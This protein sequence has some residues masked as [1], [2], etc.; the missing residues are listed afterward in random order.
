MH[1]AQL[2]KG[3]RRFFTFLT[4]RNHPYYMS[5]RSKK[6]ILV[7]LLYGFILDPLM[8]EPLA[9]A[10]IAPEHWHMTNEVQ[11]GTATAIS[12]DIPGTILTCGF[13][14]CSRT[15]D[16]G[17]IWRPINLPDSLPGTFIEPPGGHG[18]IFYRSLKYSE[19]LTS[20]VWISRNSGITWVKLVEN[21]SFGLD[22]L[23]TDF[24]RDAALYAIIWSK[25]Q[26]NQ[27]SQEFSR[28]MDVGIT[29]VAVQRTPSEAQNQ[30]WT[31]SKLAPDYR[32][33]HA[34]YRL[35]Q[36]PNSESQLLLEHSDDNGQTWQPL[37]LLDS[38]DSGNVSIATTATRP[39]SLCIELDRT[40]NIR[41]PQKNYQRLTP[42]D[43]CFSG[44][45]CTLATG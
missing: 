1:G 17:N 11:T 15:T 39:D 12:P 13:S 31:V 18:T 14:T 22:G 37:K 28:S 8:I 16:G 5:P 20:T 7:L 34:W 23:K 32:D 25:N 41:E 2:R 24:Y 42:S 19:I 21:K 38:N 40:Y 29:W 26:Q 44:R 27:F 6:F 43:F 9:Y 35:M 10:S 36:G 33:V 30:G 3:L 45:R 4:P